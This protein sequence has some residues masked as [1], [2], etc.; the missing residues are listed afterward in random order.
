MRAHFLG[1]GRAATRRGNE[2]AHL[3]AA[4][5]AQEKRGPMTPKNG[6]LHKKRQR[7]R[8]VKTGVFG[9]NKKIAKK[10]VDGVGAYGT[11]A[12]T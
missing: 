2:S 10:E 6:E 4:C 3:A 9:K 7:F 11:L 5:G 1:A 8:S 12:A